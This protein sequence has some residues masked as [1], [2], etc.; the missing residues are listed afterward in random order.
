MLFVGYLFVLINLS[1]SFSPLI[2]FRL[3]F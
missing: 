2:F 1:G 3:C